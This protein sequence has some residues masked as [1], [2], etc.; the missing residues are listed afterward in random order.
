MSARKRNLS[1]RIANLSIRSKILLSFLTV[2]VVLI[3]LGLNAL[4]RSS[5]MN[6]QVEDITRNYAL[7]VVYL[8]QMRVSVADYRGAVAREL[9]D[10]DDKTARQN[11]QTVLADLTKLHDESDAKYAPTVDPGTEADL[12]R[13][14]KGSWAAYLDISQHVHERLAAGNIGDA[15][16]YY[17]ANLVPGGTRAETAVHASMNYNVDAFRRLT[18]E[19]DATYRN[20]RWLILGV[21]VFAVAVA[22]LAGLFLVRSI[23]APVVSMT[24]AMRRLAAHDMA[25]DIRRRTA[26]TR[27][28]RWPGRCRCSRR[29]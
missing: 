12:Y 15:K 6:L 11:A 21:M 26:P 7:A 18:D 9:L 2:L 3:G 4:Q 29:P 16:A 13:E 17:T 5:A 22:S 27:S 25:A 1:A 23:A 10:A 14:T 20:G 24:D 8:D 28:A 19:V